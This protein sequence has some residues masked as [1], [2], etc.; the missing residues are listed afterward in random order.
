M[1]KEVNILAL[2]VS[3]GLIVFGT[4]YTLNS[5]YKNPSVSQAE[6]KE[7]LKENDKIQEENDEKVVLENEE[8]NSN[9][10]TETEAYKPT[11]KEE[12][13]AIKITFKEF[14]SKVGSQEDF[15]LAVVRA[16]CGACTT[17][18]PKLETIA[19][20]H[21]IPIYILDTADITNDELKELLD[22]YKTYSTPTTLVFYRG[23]E[24]TNNSIVGN[25]SNEEIEKEL[26][27]FNFIQ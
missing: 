17:Y 27:K 19:N 12:V 16:T 26:K 3:I 6:Q 23:I 24:Q 22:K 7:E 4:Y 1:K 21:K 2:I 18:T 13:G 25:I 9:I 14:K 5:D 10:V 20:K 11:I 15:V 8:A